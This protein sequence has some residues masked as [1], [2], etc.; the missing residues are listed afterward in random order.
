MYFIPTINLVLQFRNYQ[1]PIL[2]EKPCCGNIRLGDN[3]V[4]T[5]NRRILKFALL[6]LP[7][8]TGQCGNGQLVAA[9]F[10][11]GQFSVFPF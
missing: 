3:E 11:D 4:L 9:L 10:V 5:I 1:L 6:H 2:T 8:F 7:V